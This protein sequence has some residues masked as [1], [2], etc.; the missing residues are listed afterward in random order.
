MTPRPLQSSLRRPFSAS[1]RF[2]T[3]PNPPSDPK[4]PPPDLNLPVFMGR[5]NL[6]EP[7]QPK[8]KRRWGWLVIWSLFVFAGGVAAGPVLTDEAFALVERVA[9]K[10]GISV[11][12]FVESRRPAAGAVAPVPAEVPAPEPAVAPKPSLAPPPE[13][14]TGAAKAPA[15]EEQGE[16]PIA[17]A[18]PVVVPAAAAKPEPEIVAPR[19]PVE[20][21]RAAAAAPART[22]T[23]AAEAGRSRHGKG[24]VKV[25]ASASTPAKRTAGSEDPF[26]SE[27]ETGSEAKPVAPSGKSKPAE[28]AASAKSEPASKPAAARSQDSLDDLMA[29]GVAG[30][31][32]KKRESKDLDALLK[33]VQKSKPEPPPKHE[34]PPP[35]SSL[36]AAD[37]AKVMAV[38]KTRSNACAQRL[39]QQGIAELKITV[40]KGG[41]VTDVQLGGKIAN[42]PLAACIEKATRAAT[43]PP[44]SGL[45]FDYRIDAR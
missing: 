16:S 17:A 23:V 3:P 20:V 28:P 26:A 14:A 44:S 43:F 35:P 27:A 45:R 36:S 11:P 34:A 42:T 21:K 29:D 5:I 2:V 41:A 10:L 8:R 13:P 15:G 12:R 1:I 9:Q 37:I 22:E 4:A 40:G 19:E 30:S 39:G 7:P 18:K 32:G 38:V 31:K 6:P 25:A 24:A 33:D